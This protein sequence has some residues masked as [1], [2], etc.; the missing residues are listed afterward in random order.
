VLANGLNIGLRH[1]LGID[2]R[3]ISA[4]HSIS[5][6][7][8]M[9]PVDRPAFQFPALTYYY[10]HPSERMAYLTLFPI[11]SVMRANLFGYRDLHDPWLRQLR[12]QPQATLFESMP[13]LGRLTDAFEVVSPIKIR[14]VDLYVTTGHRQAGIVLI[15]DAF[16]TSCPAAGTGAGKVLTDVERLCNVHVPRWLATPAM[17]QGKI[18]AFYDD[19]VKRAYDAY[20]LDKAYSLRAFSIDTGARWRAQRTAKFVLHWARGR[21]RRVGRRLATHPTAPYGAAARGDA[22]HP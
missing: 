8:D 5:V 21:V 20:S 18:A 11:G 15:G 7:F 22:V 19:P 14:P 17:D 3:I 6:G 16:A 13:G 9:K 2:R 12:E 1:K 4:G 10:E